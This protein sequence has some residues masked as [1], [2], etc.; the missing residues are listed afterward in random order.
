MLFTGLALGTCRFPP[1]CFFYH[2]GSTSHFKLFLWEISLR[3]SSPMHRAASFIDDLVV[4]LG[5]LFGVLPKCLQFYCCLTYPFHSASFPYLPE[6]SPRVSFPL[7][8]L[9]TYAYIIY[10]HP[11]YLRVSVFLKT[12]AKS[13]TV[14]SPTAQKAIL[15]VAGADSTSAK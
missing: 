5:H 8:K 13:Y 15:N 3:E 7:L 14:L 1:V 2:P 10:C 12:E 9:C 6:S 4:L 11:G